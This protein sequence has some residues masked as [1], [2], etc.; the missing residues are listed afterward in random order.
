MP[1]AYYCLLAMVALQRLGELVLSYRNRKQLRIKG[2]S[3][4]EPVVRFS[5][6]VAVHVLWLLSSFCEPQLLRWPP[7]S[8]PVWLF[9]FSLF[10]GA[11][12]LR[13][14]VIATLGG[15]WNV[16]V[17]APQ[18]KAEESGNSFSTA[19][20]LVGK[21]ELACV[22]SGPYRLLRH[23]N[24]LAVVVEVAALPLLGRAYATA[25]VFLLAN[26]AIIVKRIRLEE[27]ALFLREGYQEK[28]SKK[29]RL[30]PFVW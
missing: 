1:V 4:V 7:L 22:S 27:R 2:F 21:E 5:P 10:L 18:S 6:M 28:F 23:P 29:S 24:Y 12:G 14:W 15:Q 13:Y 3:S 17:M 8:W 26:F 25:A 20:L 11:Q 9:V 19:N 16:G 30:V